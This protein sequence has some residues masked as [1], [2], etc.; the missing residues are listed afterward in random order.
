MKEQKNKP[1][2]LIV[3]AAKSGTTSLYHYL[4]N[5]P[6]V[7]MSTP[8]KEPKYFIWKKFVN[9]KTD[10]PIHD[11]FIQNSTI[12]NQDEYLNLFHQAG[13]AK[14]I[15]EGSV[16]YLY[17]YQMAIQNIKK[18]LGDI[19]IIIML[20]NPVE[21]AYSAY[22]HLVRDHSEFNSFDKA[23]AIE[24]DRIT[25]NYAP[26]Y[27]YRK[28]GLYYEQV[29]AYME[30][31]SNVKVIIFDDFI[32]STEKNMKEIYDFLE[33][34]SDF[35]PNN[36]K[37]IY[38]KSGIPNNKW[39]HSIITK[40]NLIKDGLKIIIPNKMIKKVIENVKDRNLKRVKMSKATEKELLNYYESDVIKL[41]ALINQNLSHWMVN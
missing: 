18:E 15:G 8:N 39:L 6:Q 20:R 38:N 25:Q 26:L 35:I 12:C 1:N 30:N 11:E 4:S 41:Q 13:E 34:D 24:E 23:L 14:A 19:K 2:F 22:T 9:L 16:M 40:P 27:H 7:Y 3:G 28:V 33:I 37:K 31:F 5:H 21:R 10:N 36:Y 32:K 29:K 17:Y